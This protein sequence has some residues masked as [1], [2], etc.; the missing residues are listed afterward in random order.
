MHEPYNIGEQA[1]TVIAQLACFNGALSQGSPSSP[2]ITNVICS[3]L[4]TQLIRLAKKHGIVSTRYVDNIT[5][6]TFNDEFPEAVIKGDV[7]NLIISNELGN[8]LKK[9]S[10][11]VNLDKV[12]LNNNFTRQ[13]VTGLIVNRFPNVKKEYIKSLRAI[14][15]KC[16]KKGIYETVLEYIDK[17]YYKNKDII[18]DLDNKERINN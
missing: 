11:S 15:H 9:N 7:S 3:P 5:L 17:G 1:A 10:F 18:R 14:L 4:D 16:C 12:F 6:S 13:E 2:I 8:I